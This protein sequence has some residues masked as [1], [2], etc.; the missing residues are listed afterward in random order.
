MSEIGHTTP[1]TAAIAVD[2]DSELTVSEQLAAAR[3]ELAQYQVRVRERAIQGWRDDNF[4][5]E[6]LNETL[7]AVGLEPYEPRYI[8]TMAA[9]I[10]IHLQADGRRGDV[11]SKWAS[12]DT[13]KIR[14]ALREAIS[15][16]LQDHAG[17]EFTL[18]DR[19]LTF[20]T[21]HYPTERTV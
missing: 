2:T 8:T 4:S 1:D 14:T 13:L 3:K 20:T 18:E 6:C 5:L 12:V 21:D 9:Q 11:A 7:T 16:V 17:G 10:G 15:R 19:A